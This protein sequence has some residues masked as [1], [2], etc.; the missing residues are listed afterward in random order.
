L[1]A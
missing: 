1:A